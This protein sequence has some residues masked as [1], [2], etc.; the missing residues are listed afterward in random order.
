MVT[1]PSWRPGTVAAVRAWAREPVAVFAGGCVGALARA[2]LAEA[3]PPG[4]G[5]WPWGTFVANLAGAFV[6]GWVAAIL[7]RGRRRAFLAT[8][9]CGALTTF[10][11]F[12]LELFELLDRD[13]VAVAAGYAAASVVLGL[14]A[15]LLGRRLAVGR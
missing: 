3:L 14:Y 5:G 2:G 15:V 8:G 10:S 4:A 7:H 11:T 9:F 6:L 1:P 12:Q 13:R